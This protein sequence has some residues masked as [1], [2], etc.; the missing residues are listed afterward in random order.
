MCCVWNHMKKVFQ[1]ILQD[2]QYKSLCTLFL[3]KSWKSRL[4]KTTTFFY[5]IHK[6][7]EISHKNLISILKSTYM[8]IATYYS[9]NFWANYIF[10]LFISKVFWKFVNWSH[11]SFCTFFLHLFLSAPKWLDVVKARSCS[12]PK[13][14]CKRWYHHNSKV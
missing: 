8:I 6:W 10:F 11:F 14:F 3:R 5:E 1:T 4:K 9:F 7:W 2:A 12:S 13:S